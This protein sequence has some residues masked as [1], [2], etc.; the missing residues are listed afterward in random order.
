MPRR[1]AKPL[2]PNL[3]KARRTLYRPLGFLHFE[4]GIYKP[5]DQPLHTLHLCSSPFCALQICFP[6]RRIPR[7]GGSTGRV[8]G[9]V[10][11]RGRSSR[12]RRRREM[13]GSQARSESWSE[14]LQAPACGRM[15]APA[16][17]ERGH[18]APGVGHG[19]RVEGV[20]RQDGL[21]RRSQAIQDAVKAGSN[22]KEGNRLEQP[23]TRSRRE[24]DE[25]ATSG[26]REGHERST[27]VRKHSEVGLYIG[28]RLVAHTQD[29]EMVTEA[30][31]E[32]LM[33]V[34]TSPRRI[35]SFGAE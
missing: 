28:R 35:P 33:M 16:L 9:S 30:C 29:L 23:E 24:G 19:A 21:S 34:S 13:L 15:S 7:V 18:S 20:A 26:R 4:D 25:R 31:S 12:V 22:W 17:G 14:C 1:R 8:D 3:K 27:R 2:Q 10:A 5:R 11:D 6:P 32:L